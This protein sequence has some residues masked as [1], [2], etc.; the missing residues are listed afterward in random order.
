[1]RGLKTILVN[2]IFC[3]YFY[4]LILQ[5]GLD[6]LYKAGGYLLCD[7]ILKCLGAAQKRLASEASGTMAAGFLPVVRT[8]YPAGWSQHG[9]FCAF[10]GVR[11]VPLI[12]PCASSGE[13]LTDH[14]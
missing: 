6:A 11:R 10:N 5:K 1:L 3:S 9:D 14:P 8:Y 12:D 4:I 13:L 2:L 7:S